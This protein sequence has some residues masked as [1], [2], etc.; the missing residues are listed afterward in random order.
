MYNAKFPFQLVL[1]GLTG[2]VAPEA[3]GG[4]YYASK[5]ADAAR[6]RE[7]Y[8]LKNKSDA[9]ASIKLFTQALFVFSGSRIQR[10]RADKGGEYTN[11]E[12]EDYCL[13][14]NHA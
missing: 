4:Y 12:F 5:F 11:K 3:L 9:V 6:W 2:P 14:K 7:I 10:L 1:T 8:L 13:G